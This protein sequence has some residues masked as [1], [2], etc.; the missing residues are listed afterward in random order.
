MLTVSLPPG[1]PSDAPP[2]YQKSAPFLRGREK[3]VLCGLLDDIY[4]DN[5]GECVVFLWVEQIRTFLQERKDEYF[6]SC[7]SGVGND[8]IVVARMEEN[9]LATALHNSSLCPKITTGG[10]IEDRKSVFQGHTAPVKSA[11]D[12][13]AVIAKL[14]ENKKIAHATH[15]IYAFRIFCDDKQT[16]LG[17][18]VRMMVRMLLGEDS[19]TYWR[20]WTSVDTLVVV[21]RWYGGT[22]LGPDRFKHP[23]LAHAMTKFSF[24]VD[25]TVLQLAFFMGYE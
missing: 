20:Y 22:H 19:S 7:D 16:W 13:K 25:L 4:V 2:T 14:Y 15:N 17:V 11:D 1:Y 18:M 10:T 21:S 12:V 6:D 3:E 24:I 9:L 5:L 23:F 8:E